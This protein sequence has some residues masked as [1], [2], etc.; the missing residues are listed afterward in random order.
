[1]NLKNFEKF[2]GTQILARGLDYYHSD[3]IASIEE[4]E[5]NEFE[6]TVEGRE[7]Y[8]VKVDLDEHGNITYTFCDCP[9]DLGEY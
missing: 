7:L 1:M 5:D 4:I 9:Y 2:A 8:K 6:A 3:C